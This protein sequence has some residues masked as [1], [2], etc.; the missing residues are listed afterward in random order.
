MSRNVRPG[1]TLVMLRAYSPFLFDSFVRNPGKFSNSIPVYSSPAP[2]RGH[3]IG[4][5]LSD[6]RRVDRAGCSVPGRLVGD[7]R[8]TG[9]P[10]KCCFAGSGSDGLRNR[11]FLQTM[12]TEDT[13][14]AM[15]L[16]LLRYPS[17]DPLVV[18]LVAVVL[19]AVSGIYY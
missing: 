18:C 7:G 10:Y 12:Q 13:Y 17:W 4:P 3:E 14:S 15:L 16:G 9:Q 2:M 1:I 19:L 5:P 6:E 8:A 11:T